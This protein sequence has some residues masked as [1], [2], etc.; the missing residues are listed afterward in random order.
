MIKI[1]P[2]IVGVPIE[3]KSKQSVYMKHHVTNGKA[4]SSKPGGMDSA[5]EEHH[6]LNSVDAL[7]ATRTEIGQAPGIGAIN[8]D[9]QVNDPSL[10][11]T[12]Y[13]TGTSHHFK[14]GV[15]RLTVKKVL[16]SM[17]GAGEFGATYLPEEGV[18]T[19]I[20]SML[21]PKM[22]HKRSDRSFPAENRSELASK[23]NSSSIVDF[24]QLSIIATQGVSNVPTNNRIHFADASKETALVVSL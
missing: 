21:V 16:E 15:Q 18:E 7:A 10:R 14:T 12:L 3:V 1:M 22:K 24:A 11:S 23:K 2:T 17:S 9:Q 20:N 13:I 6:T 8:G 19:G 5:L 4:M